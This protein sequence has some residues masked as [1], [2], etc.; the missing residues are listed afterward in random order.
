MIRSTP[1]HVK[2]CEMFACAQTEILNNFLCVEVSVFMKDMHWN[3]PPY[4]DL[5]N[6]AAQ[7]FEKMSQS[8][9]CPAWERL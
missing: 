1:E 2:V 6:I 7:Y 5:Q 3:T 4:N 8:S 9:C